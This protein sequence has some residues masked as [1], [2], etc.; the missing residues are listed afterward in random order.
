[1]ALFA[2]LDCHSSQFYFY[3]ELDMNQDLQKTKQH[4]VIIQH[5]N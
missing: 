5:A 1:M 4:T 3:P 2:P